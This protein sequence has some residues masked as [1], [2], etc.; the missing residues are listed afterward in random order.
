VRETGWK[1]ICALVL[2]WTTWSQSQVGA[3]PDC[4]KRRHLRLRH[5]Q[6][7]HALSLA[8]SHTAAT[9]RAAAPNTSMAQRLRA[10][11]ET[12]TR[13]VWELQ[14]HLL[15]L[16]FLPD[17][18]PCK[19]V[20]AGTENGDSLGSVH[21]R[22]QPATTA[23][24]ASPPRSTVSNDSSCVE[25]GSYGPGGGGSA[26]QRTPLPSGSEK[27]CPCSILS[28]LAVYVGLHLRQVGITMPRCLEHACAPWLWH[29][30]YDLTRQIH[31]KG[32]ALSAGIYCFLRL[33]EAS[34]QFDAS[35]SLLQGAPRYLDVPS[36]I[37]RNN[38]V[39][40]IIAEAQR[41]ARL[42]MHE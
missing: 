40:A 31:G 1:F 34:V 19:M 25:T 41:V 10:Q 42:R 24:N 16:G 27:V 26:Y 12:Q 4:H 9:F 30:S 28:T 18:L 20:L 32:R 15:D 35:R 8:A 3:M 7:V 22:P 21:A 14:Q 5:A 29:S 13:K 33:L 6:D 38:E 11:H 37:A 17:E 36:T 2:A 23:G 39:A